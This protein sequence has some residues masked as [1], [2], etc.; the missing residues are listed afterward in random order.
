MIVFECLWCVMEIIAVIV[1]LSKY[2]GMQE[3]EK[4]GSE[5]WIRGYQVSG[6]YPRKCLLFSFPF[7]HR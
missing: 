2:I 3:D 4:R 1:T 6:T 5:S 7:V